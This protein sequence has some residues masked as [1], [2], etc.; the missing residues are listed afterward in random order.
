MP[1]WFETI[2]AAKGKIPLKK[3]VK[4]RMLAHLVGLSHYLGWKGGS[5]L[6]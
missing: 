2:H 4:K 3:Q 5:L 6:F 1:E